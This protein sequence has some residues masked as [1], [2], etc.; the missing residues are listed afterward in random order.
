MS[1]TEDGVIRVP[2]APRKEFLEFHRRNTRFACMVAHRRAGKTVACV[3]EAVGRGIYS[4][5]KRPRYAY[6]G[7]LLKQAKKTA[8][9]YLKEYT[10]GLTK[11]KPSES[12]LY[13]R[14]A[15]NE[16]EIGIYGADNPDS[17]RGQYFDGVILDE[18][19]DMSPSL[20]GAVI[21]PTLAD[22]KGWAAF[23]G[24]FKGRN[25]FYRIYR[26]AQGLDLQPGEDVE[27]ISKNWYNFLLSIDNSTI[28]SEEEK[29]LQKSEMEEEEWEQEYRCNPNAVVRGT[30]Y[31]K[32]ISQMEAQG[33]INRL[34]VSW[35]PEFAVDVYT[36]LGVGDSTALWYVQRR[37]DG[38]AILHYEEAHS[39]ALPY[40][41]GL[42][43]DKPYQY[44]KIWLPHDA[45]A[46]TLQTG[47]STIQLFLAE[48]KENPFNRWDRSDTGPIIRV[49]PRLDVQDGINAVRKILLDCWFGSSAMDGVEALRAY[50]REYDE[51]K[52]V[53]RETPNHDWSSHGADGFRQFALVVKGIPTKEAQEGEVEKP[54]IQVATQFQLEELFQ[55]RERNLRM[56][57]GRV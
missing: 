53:F 47:R 31:A 11:K 27:Y 37:P 54:K 6:I 30:Y 56:N 29:R 26:R 12:E 44:G 25:H 41:Y 19:G 20:W 13:V 48:D 9:E 21:L 32:L 17:F 40:Y 39:Q 55:H 28:L 24:T 3:N 10:I 4:R 42:L 16:A 49:V 35:D 18:Y 51:D 50:K 52:K 36:D 38:Y 23:I 14:L 1:E 5:K 22:R 43:R 33:R 34:D 15:H 45:R 7:P 57:R 2:Y 8:W 46:R